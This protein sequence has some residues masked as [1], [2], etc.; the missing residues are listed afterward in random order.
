MYNTT[1]LPR[2]AVF[3]L[4]AWGFC[5]IKKREKNLNPSQSNLPA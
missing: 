3:K 2:E 1:Y 4:V 5:F